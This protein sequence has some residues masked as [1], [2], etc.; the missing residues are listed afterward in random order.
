MSNGIIKWMRKIYLQIISSIAFY[1]MIIAFAFVILSW[2]MLMIDFSEWGTGIKAQL[3]WIRLKDAA[4]ARTIASTIAASILSLTV[5]S[6]SL[7]M[8]ILTQAASQISN[9]TLDSM[10][11]NRFQQVVL[12]FYIGTIVYAL[13]LLNTIRDVKSGIYVPAL[14]IYLLILLTVVDIFLFIYF[15]HFA[16][17]TVK[18][19]TIINRIHDQTTKSLLRLSDKGQP[20]KE[21][22][23]L[24]EGITITA[25]ESGYYQGFDKEGLVRWTERNNVIVRFLYPVGTYHLKETPFL[26]IYDH[27]P[28]TKKREELFT[29]IDFYHHQLPDHHYY[30][31]FLHLSEIAIKSL[32]PGINDPSTAV[33]A[34]HALT[35]LFAIRCGAEPITRHKGN[36]GIVR[37]I[38]EEWSFEKLFHKCIDPIWHYGQNDLFVQEAM[39]D[40]LEQLSML[41]KNSKYKGLFDKLSAEIRLKQTKAQV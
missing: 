39:R 19:G 25:N 2:V 38:Q 11:S 13:I 21:I 17:Q 1:P 8:I 40:M 33:L 26:M 5:F 15:L 29:F 18:Y 41:D 24:N 4:T 28:E 23:H 9:R 27:N 6:F 35:D 10:I 31:G 3:D 14:S 12:G 34:I 16:T 20:E 32:S 7:V 22:I 37:I 30:F 36:S